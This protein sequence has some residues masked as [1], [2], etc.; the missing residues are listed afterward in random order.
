MPFHRMLLYQDIL[1]PLSAKYYTFITWIL[2]LLLRGT[3]D[4]CISVLYLVNLMIHLLFLSN[5]SIDTFVVSMCTIILSVNNGS[6][7]QN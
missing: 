5:L 3:I 7:L 4:F 2:S 6:L 1:L